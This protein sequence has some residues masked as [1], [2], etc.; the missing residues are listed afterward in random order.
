MANF[1]PQNT[2][3]HDYTF[4]T[5]MTYTFIMNWARVCKGGQY[6]QEHPELSRSFRFSLNSFLM[7]SELA[8]A[9]FISIS[10]HHYELLAS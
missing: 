7:A 5:T 4:D 1:V 2:K 10:P 3:G 6:Q 8:L 9:I